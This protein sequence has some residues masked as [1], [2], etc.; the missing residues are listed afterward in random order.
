MLLIPLQQQAHRRQ[1]TAE[2]RLQLESI[3]AWHHL[4][5]RFG[6]RGRFELATFVSGVLRLNPAIP[7]PP[8]DTKRHIVEMVKYI[9]D[10]WEAYQPYLDRCQFV[11]DIDRAVDAN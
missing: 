1:T 9:D 10:N 5:D 3:P 8:R 4:T 11:D 7:R 6:Q 2:R